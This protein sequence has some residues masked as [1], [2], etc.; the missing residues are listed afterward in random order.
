MM[1]PVRILW[2][3]G[4]DSTYRFLDLVINQNRVV[5]PYYIIDSNRPSFSKEIQTMVG[6]KKLIFNR[7]PGSQELIKP[8]IFTELND[9]QPDSKISQKFKRLLARRYLGS[10]YDWLARFA[11]QAKINDLELCIHADDKAHYFL[12]SNV[13][14][15]QVDGLEFSILNK[16]LIDSDLGIF[17]NFHF[18]LFDL[19]KLDIQAMSNQSGF[20]DIMEKTWFCFTPI[21]GKPCGKCAPCDYTI[22]EG[23]GRRVPIIS[24]L[25]WLL[26]YQPKQILRRIYKKINK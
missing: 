9:V 4:W 3:G 25:R 15:T 10:Q 17:K 5:E 14:Q 22:I 20:N 6:I 16:D 1:K 2:T 23:L 24:R 21:N 26:Y 12:Q 18:P 13:H 8:T 11:A 7:M 19:T